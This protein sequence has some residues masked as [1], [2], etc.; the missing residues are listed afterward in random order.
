MK[1]RAAQAMTAG[2]PLIFNEAFTLPPDYIIKVTSSAASG[3]MDV[4]VTTAVA[5]AAASPRAK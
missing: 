4:M 5:V 3:D 1:L 2:T